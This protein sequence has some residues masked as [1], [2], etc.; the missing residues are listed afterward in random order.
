MSTFVL[1]DGVVYHTYSTYAR[2]LVGLWGMYQWLD[3]AP[4][5]RNEAGPWFRRSPC[6]IN[7]LDDGDRAGLHHSSPNCNAGEQRPRQES[8]FVICY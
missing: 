8:M 2:G 5:G 1:E 6:K 4:S 7:D 3:R